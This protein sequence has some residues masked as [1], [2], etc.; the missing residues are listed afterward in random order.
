MTLS[1]EGLRRKKRFGLIGHPLGHSLSPEIHEAIFAGLG[2]EAEYRLYDLE[3]LGLEVPAL[4]ET[5]DGFNCTIPYKRDLITF[6]D[7]IS[8]EAEVYG[9]VNT[10]F[11]RKGYNTDAAGFLAS[12]FAFAGTRVLILGTGG[13]SHTFA[14][15]VAGEGASEVVF[16]TR[17]PAKAADWLTD[18]HSGYPGTV[19]RA[20]AEVEEA[21]YSAGDAGFHYILNGT[22]LGMW[23]ESAG[24]PLDR[25][26]YLDLLKR[27]EMR[28]VFDAIYNPVATRFLLLA[29]SAG[30][31]AVSGLDMLIFQAVEAERIWHPELA[32]R[33]ETK[34]FTDAIQKLKQTLTGYLFEKFPLR[35]V[36]T[37]FMG[38]GK[39]ATGRD[40]A[41]LLGP[42][43]TYI[44][45]DEAIE[46]RAGLAI[47]EIFATQGE[48]AFRTLEREVLGEILQGP[49]AVL[50]STG[51]G[52]MVQEG[53]VDLVR[54]YGGQIVLLD[55]S[56][57]TSMARTSGGDERP[58]LNQDLAGVKALYEKRRPL[59]RAM[60]DLIVDADRERAER[61][62]FIFKSLGGET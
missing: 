12:G 30:V 52:T 55:S 50:L 38:S 21:V 29:R 8:P 48:A 53:A 18:L 26:V 27:P 35:L 41:G 56:F 11:Q 23:P 4:L 34:P 17:S 42:A 51:G 39:S 10:V 5:L 44:D 58:L 6:L 24:L 14:H 7:E 49:G 25:E 16:L 22:P 31:R 57:E 36:L 3:D 13:V 45:L 43:V 59:Y 9:S 47:K 32:E 62:S 60:A 2:I 1:T 40:L 37:G 19:F 33:F 28:G 61:A 46:A 20:V 54:S 15:C